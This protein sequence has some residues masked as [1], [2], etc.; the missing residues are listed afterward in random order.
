MGTGTYHA[1]YVMW[2]LVGLSYHLECSKKEGVRCMF[3][4]NISCLRKIPHQDVLCVRSWM[5]LCAITRYNCYKPGMDI[6]SFECAW[7]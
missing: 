4:P 1:I 3:C 5:C 2:W 6:V 7:P